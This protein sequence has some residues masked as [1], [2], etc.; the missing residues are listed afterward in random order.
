MDDLTVQ[1][2]IFGGE[3]VLTPEPEAPRVVS[4]EQPRLFEPQYEGQLDMSG[5]NYPEERQ[6]P[7][8]TT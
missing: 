5:D 2:D 3:H 1:I 7:C 8:S 4:A 6:D